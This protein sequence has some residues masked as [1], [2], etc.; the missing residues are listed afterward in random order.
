MERLASQKSFRT[1]VSLRLNL[2]LPGSGPSSRAGPRFVS[3]PF[4][5]RGKRRYVC[6][7]R[8]FQ[9]KQDILVSAQT[10]ILRLNDDNR[11]QSQRQASAQ[12]T[13]CK[14]ETIRKAWALWKIRR[15]HEPKLLALLLALQ[16]RCH[17]GLALLG[18][19]IVV[20]V[21]CGLIV[22]REFFVLLFHQ[23][24]HLKSRLVSSNLF[25]QVFLCFCLLDSEDIELVNL[26]PK[27]LNARRFRVR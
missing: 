27:L 11:P 22:A 15:I 23:R 14:Q 17:R 9:I 25:L 10:L 16:I 8:K 5:R 12:T 20:E 7:D 3:F 26:Y 6:Q 4:A 2:L 19:Q 13:Q 21:E 18:E 1:Y 24:A